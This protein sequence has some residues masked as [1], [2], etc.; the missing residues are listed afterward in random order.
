MG[1]RSAGCKFPVARIKKIIQADEEVGKVAASTPVAVCK[2]LE[3][4]IDHILDASAREAQTAG[5]RKVT[6]YH[7]CVPHLRPFMPHMFPCPAGG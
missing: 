7:L 2:A 4:F 6:P 1:K 5:A 3:M